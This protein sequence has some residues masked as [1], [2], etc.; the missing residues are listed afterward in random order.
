MPLYPDSSQSDLIV[1]ATVDDV[2]E[3]TAVGTIVVVTE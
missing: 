1:V 2:P 3:G